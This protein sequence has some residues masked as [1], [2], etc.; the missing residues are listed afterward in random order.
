MICLTTNQSSSNGRSVY[1]PAVVWLI[2]LLTSTFS[3]QTVFAQLTARQL[4]AP[5]VEQ[6]SDQFQDVELAVVEF[7]K[8]N[9]KLA[10]KSLELASKQHPELAPPSTMMA[11]LFLSTG[12]VSDA[13]AEVDQAVIDRPADPEAVI[14]LG[15]LALRGKKL[16]IAE[17]AYTRGAQLAEQYD[18]NEFRLRNLMIRIHAGIGSLYEM[19][20]R[21][22]L[23]AESLKKWLVMEPKNPIPHGSLAR[24]FFK[25]KQYSE[26][27]ESLSTLAKMDENTPPVGIAMGR[28]YSDVGM[29][30]E[31]RKYMDLAIKS[32]GD[33]IRVRLTVAE[34][35]L[36][37]GLIPLAKENV[38]A[39]L[40]LE[41]DS[42]GGLVLAARI[43]RVEGDLPEAENLLNRAVLQSPSSFTA[44]NELSRV[45]AGSDDLK[46]KKTA[47]QYARR[48]FQISQNKNTSS[49][50]EAI[51]TYAWILLQNDRAR[52]AEAALN[53]LPNGTSISH[54]NAYLTAQ[55]YAQRGRWDVAANALQ[56]AIASGIPFPGQDQARQMLEEAKEK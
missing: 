56:S 3:H 35:A 50:A 55:V 13:E 36:G 46:K 10:K 1:C 31:A 28:L 53:A 19:Q 2:F 40:Q 43:A 41:E 11:L 38:K 12:R 9:F 34:W 47:L 42:L 8:G 6:Y 20:G 15:D 51:I 27:E 37:V 48:N 5:T 44:T 30:D 17:L 16:T 52:E 22:A 18:G 39:A 54:E 7:G 49:R 32:K 14:L 4:L 29:D 45:L 24:V 23:A 33:D 25:M 26:A 21:H